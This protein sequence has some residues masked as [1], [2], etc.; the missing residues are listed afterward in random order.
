MVQYSVD[1]GTCAMFPVQGMTESYLNITMAGSGPNN[2]SDDN[3][4]SSAT[5]MKT[6]FVAAVAVLVASQM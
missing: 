2:S 4:S 1:F 6:A 3:N 5:S